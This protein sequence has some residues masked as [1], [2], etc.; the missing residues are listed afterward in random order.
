[1][2]DL[3]FRNRNHLEVSIMIRNLW[4]LRKKLLNEIRQIKENENENK[5]QNKRS[6]P[7]DK[8]LLQTDTSRDDQAIK[9]TNNPL[10]RRN[11]SGKRNPPQ[12]D[13][14]QSNRTNPPQRKLTQGSQNPPR[15]GLPQNSKKNRR[16]KKTP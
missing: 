8:N 11:T 14:P 7:Q 13:M 6:S 9:L 12:G 3:L 10:Q 15:G 16:L 5:N 2:K 1:M 4:I